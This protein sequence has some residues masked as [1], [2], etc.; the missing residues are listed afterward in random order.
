MN[1]GVKNNYIEFLFCI[2]LVF[3]SSGCGTSSPPLPESHE[4]GLTRRPIR[5]VHLVSDKYPVK[6]DTELSNL[7]PAL[8]KLVQLHFD[9]NIEFAPM[10]KMTRVEFEKKFHDQIAPWKKQGT[11]KIIKT[12]E[13]RE[14]LK[15]YI[16]NTWN[17]YHGRLD[18]IWNY[19]KVSPPESKEKAIE[20]I[21]NVFETRFN[22]SSEA[23][24]DLWE[25]IHF[26]R[27]LLSTFDEYDRAPDIILANFPIRWGGG[28]NYP[29]LNTLVRG[30]RMYAFDSAYPGNLI[31]SYRYLE[32]DTDILYVIVHSFTRL[33]D[34]CGESYSSDGGILV[35]LLGENAKQLWNPDSSKLLKI[36]NRQKEWVTYWYY[37][38][39]RL[40][41]RYKE[42]GD[43]E[44]FDKAAEQLKYYD[45]D[46]Y[47]KCPA[48]K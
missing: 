12:P 7:L 32:S 46:I 13:M 3:M 43:K 18:M 30:N 36:C 41:H 34:A 26:W 6:A 35:P 9:R 39:C 44:K 31:V 45:K 14:W 17:G 33:L 24:D 11:L 29:G 19:L 21:M 48:L 25:Y 4:W 40:A 22:E 37:H 10:E 28:M 16:T 5:V 1:W 2:W 23:T 27:P 38:Q 47:Y 42:S 15:G 20:I 8:T